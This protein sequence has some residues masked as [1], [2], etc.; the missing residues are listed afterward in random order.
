[1]GRKALKKNNSRGKRKPGEGSVLETRLG[2]ESRDG[3]NRLGYRL[4][5]L[6]GKQQKERGGGVGPGG[7]ASV[8]TLAFLNQK[9]SVIS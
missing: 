1:M 4:P 8:F 6:A 9:A 7:R 5:R 3:D 2:S